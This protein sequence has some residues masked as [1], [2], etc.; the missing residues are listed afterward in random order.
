MTSSFR[1]ASS[2]TVPPCICTGGLYCTRIST[3][4]SFSACTRARVRLHLDYGSN[5]AYMNWSINGLMM[6]TSGALA[7]SLGVGL[8]LGFCSPV[9][10]SRQST[11]V[12]RHCHHEAKCSC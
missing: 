1:K 12:S 11:S 2:D 8:L 5:M 9:L 7:S 10:N 4:R 6:A 3:L